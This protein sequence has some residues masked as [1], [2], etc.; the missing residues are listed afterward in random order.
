MKNFSLNARWRA[1]QSVK[2]PN[3]MTAPMRASMSNELPKT[4][5]ILTQAKGFT[6]DD[7]QVACLLVKRVSLA[8]NRR[9]LAALVSQPLA[10]ALSDQLQADLEAFRKRQ[11]DPVTTAQALSGSSAMALFQAQALRVAAVEQQQALNVYQ[12]AT[13]LSHGRPT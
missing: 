11:T 4:P 9:D 6:V 10:G 8:I 3:C 7:E 1:G 2:P 13:D 12:T 5:D